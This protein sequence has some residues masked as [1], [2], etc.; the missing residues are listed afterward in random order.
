[1]PQGT[2]RISTSVFIEHLSSIDRMEFAAI[3]AKLLLPEQYSVVEL[4]QTSREPWVD[5]VLEAPEIPDGAEVN[6][7]YVADYDPETGE[8]KTRLER[9]DFTPRE[10]S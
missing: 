6:P 9:I 1:M 8:R 5:I 3:K 4:R 2:M 10:A 7:V